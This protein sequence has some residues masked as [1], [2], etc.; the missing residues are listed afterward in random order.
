LK[1]HP[2]KNPNCKESATEK[3]QALNELCKD[4]NPAGG[5]R[6][7]TIKRK[8]MNKR[9]TIKRKTIKRKTMN[10]RK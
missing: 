2:D 9:K 10:K 3:M 8:T 4:V 6:R 1:L 7:K 5:R